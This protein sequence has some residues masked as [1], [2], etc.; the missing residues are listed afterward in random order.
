MPKVGNKVFPYTK[1]GKEDA[2]EEGKKTGKS[3][4]KGK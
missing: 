2:K 3:V 1:K 4:K